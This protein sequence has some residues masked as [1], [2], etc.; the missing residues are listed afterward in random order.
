MKLLRILLIGLAA[1]CVLLAGAAAVALNS[2]V[3]TWAARRI[4]AER[5]QWRASLGTVA[6][7]PGEVDLTD[8]QAERSGARLTL[9]ALRAEFPL[10]SA[11]I[12][13][14]LLVR[15]LDASGWTL[16]LSRIPLSRLV[17]PGALRS[18]AA[19]NTAGAPPRAGFSLLSSAY[20]Q[21][22]AMVAAQQAFAG[23][24]SRLRLPFD[25]QI[26]AVDLQGDVLLPPAP[27]A[28]PIRV[29]VGFS[30]G[31]LEAGREGLF[32]FSLHATTA[33]AG[34]PV[35]AVAAEG[36]LTAAM[37]TPRTFSRLAVKVDAS[38]TGGNIPPGTKLTTEIS[39]AREAA[40]ES[41]MVSLTG[42][43]RP[44]AILRATLADDTHALAGTWRIDASDDDL[45]PFALGRPLPVFVAAGSGRFDTDAVLDRLHASGRLSLT[46]DRLGALQRELSAFGAVKLTAEFDV[47]HRDG[48]L[49]VDQLSVALAGLQPIAS[50]QALQAFTFNIH[51]G[52]LKVADPAANLLG[53]ALEDVPA[54]WAQPFLPGIGVTGGSLHGDLAVSARSGGL[55]L[56]S[57]SPL[58]VA[59]LSLTRAGQPLLMGADLSLAVS[60]DYAPQGWQIEI[61]P[62]SVRRGETAIATF[63]LRVGRLAGADQPVK[64]TG[65]ADADLGLLAPVVAAGPTLAHGAFH[66]DFTASYGASRSYEGKFT[67]SGLEVSHA[68]AGAP[69]TWPAI[70]GHVRADVEADGKWTLVAPLVFMTDDRKSDLN[71]AGT[72]VPTDAGWGIDGRLT[73]EE[74]YADDLKLLAGAFIVT[75]V[76]PPMTPGVPAGTPAPFWTGVSGQLALGL[77]HVRLQQTD[78]NDLGGTLRF[79]PSALVWQALK[80]SVGTGGVMTLDGSLAFAAGAAPYA[81]QTSVAVENFDYGAF[82]RARHPG[83][84]PAVEGRFKMTGR[85][86]SAAQRL[87]ELADHAQG[88]L[89]LSS[90]S[91]LFRALQ[92]DV[93][94]SLKQSP[95]LISQALDSVG[96][97]FGLKADKTAEAKK[98]LD[99]Q[100]KLVVAL[101]E[102]L[103]EVPYD[104]IDVVAHR[105]SDLDIHCTEFALIAPEIRLR[106]TGTI[107][108]VANTAI[109]DQP[110]VFDGQLSARASL[111][112][113]LNGIGLLGDEKD[114]LGYTRMSQPFHL[115]GTLNAVDESQWEDTLVK[116]ALHKATGGILGKLLGK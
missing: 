62:G 60:A 107:S 18:I 86:T 11:G 104:Q 71:L 8:V 88:D 52:E 33:V 56:R 13:H 114:D 67:L 106:G 10:L 35:S 3:Q 101:A 95:A 9:P 100:G 91:G 48:E 102:R 32:A 20:A 80:V 46:A 43:N 113:A 108:Y 53:L 82:A 68:P 66:G 7:T 2:R 27:G 31:G 79:E 73:S 85:V 25:L 97:L 74:A 78:W 19:A 96:S 69:A 15:R 70:S 90:K 65:R 39:A 83:T 92:A 29:H 23:L 110:L 44:L 12:H 59:D 30:G 47:A 1:S 16:D 6:V 111:A 98:L 112:D 37:A 116:S 115:G 63:A 50:I 4:L 14:R 21:Q 77:K 5:P 87:P 45:A 34:T 94:D 103:R 57:A 58:T 41:Y 26:E 17:G 75:G 28:P 51:T 89:Q 49:R 40:G 105:G 54:A 24:F 22:A 99:K 76:T 36:T 64:A 42:E 38:A 109:G 55:G 84:P 61:S 72:L 81:L 93:A